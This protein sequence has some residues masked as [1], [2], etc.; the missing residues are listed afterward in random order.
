MSETS[1]TTSPQILRPLEPR[2]WSRLTAC[3][4]LISV[5]LLLSPLLGFVI[6][7][8]AIFFVTT[9]T[10]SG[11]RGWLGKL[12][13]GCVL[14][15]PARLGGAF[16]SSWWGYRTGYQQA[17][18]A[19]ARG[20]EYFFAAQELRGR[21]CLVDDPCCPRFAYWG[22]RR[23]GIREGLPTHALNPQDAIDELMKR[24]ALLSTTMFR[25]VCLYSDAYHRLD[26][27][28]ERGV[29][30]E[31]N[32]KAVV[33]DGN[34]MTDSDMRLVQAFAWFAPL[35]YVEINAPLITENGIKMLSLEGHERNWNRRLRIKVLQISRSQLND[36]AL[37]QLTNQRQQPFHDGTTLTRAMSQDRILEEALVGLEAARKRRA[38]WNARNQ[39]GNSRTE[40]SK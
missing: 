4:G 5:V 14:L 25:D 10:R 16:I 34:S 30:F 37:S 33:L 22:G 39:R 35:D 7:S 1:V 21:W 31:A 26:E 28:I 13:L 36:E 40:A 9:M 12:V 15:I 29:L 32:L 17:I 3:S 11:R 24:G 27:Y 38:Q 23:A 2:W 18:E 8:V 20:E 6:S 19:T